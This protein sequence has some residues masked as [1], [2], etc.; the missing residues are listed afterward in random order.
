MLHKVKVHIPCEQPKRA[1]NSQEDDFT[2]PRYKN[3]MEEVNYE[4]KRITQHYQGA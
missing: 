3:I 2:V 4:Q 1:G